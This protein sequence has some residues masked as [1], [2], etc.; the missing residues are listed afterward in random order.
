MAVRAAMAHV[1]GDILQSVGVCVSAALIWAFNDCWLGARAR[2]T[3]NVSRAVPPPPPALERSRS[4]VFVHCRR[5]DADGISY[6]YRADPI[7][8][9]LFSILVIW[10]T[11][12]TVQEA[13]HVLMAGV[14]YGIDT[15]DLLQRLQ[16]IPSVL[17]VH[18]LHVWTLVGSKINIWAHLTVESHAD[19]TQVLYA[20]QRVA[21]SIHCHHTCF[22]LEDVATYDRRVDGSGCFE[23][24]AALS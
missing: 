19:H 18:D 17:D 24:P 1:I 22:Q 15:R 12:G 10:S 5:A 4:C 7:C 11:T 9:F 6:W 14:P 20:A 3:A 21:R 8:T 23:P 2:A 13:M 16:A